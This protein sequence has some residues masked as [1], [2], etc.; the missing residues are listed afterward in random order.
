MSQLS[1]DFR[2]T[3]VVLCQSWEVFVESA[4][5]LN[6]VFDQTKGAEDLMEVK[7]LTAIVNEAAGRIMQACAAMGLTPADRSRVQVPEKKPAK[8][9]KSRFFKPKLAKAGA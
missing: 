8:S 9:E 4:A 6:Y 7:R 5:R 1:P 3:M 2:E